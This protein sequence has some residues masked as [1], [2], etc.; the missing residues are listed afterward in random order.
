MVVYC[1]NKDQLNK[2]HRKVLNWARRNRIEVNFNKSAVL[3]IRVDARTPRSLATYY[4][5][6]FLL[7]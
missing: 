7:K 3:E 4:R 1:N 6:I 5:G 2:A